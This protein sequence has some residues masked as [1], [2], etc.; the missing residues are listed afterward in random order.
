MTARQMFEKLGY[1]AHGCAEAYI[2]YERVNCFNERVRIEFYLMRRVFYAQCN[3]YPHDIDM[4]EFK[5]I[6]QQLEELRWI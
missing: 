4:A 2:C 5:A 1:K 3:S 6:Q